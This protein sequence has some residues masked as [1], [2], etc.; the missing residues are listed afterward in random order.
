MTEKVRRL[1]EAEKALTMIK[2]QRNVD[3]QTI[4]TAQQ[5]PRGKSTKYSRHVYVTRLLLSYGW[6]LENGEWGELPADDER[7][8]FNA[9]GSAR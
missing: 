5:R 9:D 3:P 1:A 2:E 8:K 7:R 6:Y 4:A